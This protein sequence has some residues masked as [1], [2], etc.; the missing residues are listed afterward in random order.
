MS[1]E[2]L[3]ESEPIWKAP[4]TPAPWATDG[5]AVWTESEL[6]WGGDLADPADPYPRSFNRP[7]QSMLLISAAPDLYLAAEDLLAAIELRDT[8]AQNAALVALSRALD[9][10]RGRGR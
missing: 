5:T 6:C 10:A 2:R 1:E 9:K 8:D 4:F 3:F 7:K